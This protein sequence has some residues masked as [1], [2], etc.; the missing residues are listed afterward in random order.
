VLHY[1]RPFRGEDRGQDHNRDHTRED[2]RPAVAVAAA[3]WADSSHSEGT[4]GYPTGTGHM[5]PRP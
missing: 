2:H 5:L 3:G 4:S 1:I